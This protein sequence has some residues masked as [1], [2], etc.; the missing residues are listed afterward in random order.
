MD[1]QTNQGAGGNV[2]NTTNPNPAA[3][4]AGSKTF[5]ARMASVA[6]AVAAASKSRTGGG[7]SGPAIAMGRS[8][9]RPAPLPAPEPVAEEAESEAEVEVEALAETPTEPETQAQAEERLDR[10]VATRGV[11]EPVKDEDMEFWRALFEGN[12]DSPAS[13]AAECGLHEDCG[14]ADLAHIVVTTSRLREPHVITVCWKGKLSFYETVDEVN[15]TADRP[16]R[17]SSFAKLEDAEAKAAALTAQW[18]IGR[19][20]GGKTGVVGGTTSADEIKAKGKGRGRFRQASWEGSAQRQG[21][22]DAYE[23]K[24]WHQIDAIYRRVWGTDAPR[25]R[26]AGNPPLALQA[27]AGLVST[28]LAEQKARYAKTSAE[29]LTGDTRRVNLSGLRARSEAERQERKQA[30]IERRM[31]LAAGKLAKLDRN[32][33]AAELILKQQAREKFRRM[34]RR[35]W[36]MRRGEQVTV[37]VTFAQIA[38]PTPVKPAKRSNRRTTKPVYRGRYVMF[39]RRPRETSPC[40]INVGFTVHNALVERDRV[41]KAMGQHLSSPIPQRGQSVAGKKDPKSKK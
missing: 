10:K 14:N 15:A 34:A 25:P 18:G 7:Q 31:A 1:Q 38:K 5:R 21:S 20:V 3:Q 23:C 22:I 2:G 16:R 6:A 8:W 12:Q 4:T 26:Q 29:P 40:A 17:H 32:T 13:S 39:N 33:P 36:Q 11:G 24:F 27:S 41:L 28:V 30:T 35:Q 9:K 37:Q 19:R